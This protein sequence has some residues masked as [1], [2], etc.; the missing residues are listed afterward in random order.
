MKKLIILFLLFFLSI[1]TK[2]VFGG[3]FNLSSI[4]QVN[5]SGKQISQWWY[6]GSNPIFKGETIV[7]SSVAI[8]IDGTEAEAIV[9]GDGN[10]TYSP[11]GIIDGDHQIVLTSN[12][13]II[14]FTLT[15]GVD[16][17]NWDV[18]NSDDGNNALPA[19]GVFYPTAILMISGSGLFLLA[20]KL[21]N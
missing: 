5:T 8:S 18:V 6:S 13:S 15:T 7:G 21:T 17:V 4:S 11:G 9:D 20:K 16:N 3:G 2:N 14:S 19:A 1:S 10:W 12:G